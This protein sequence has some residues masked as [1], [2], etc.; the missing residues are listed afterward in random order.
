MLMAVQLFAARAGAIA[1]GMARAKVEAAAD[2]A[3][4]K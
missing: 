3:Q 4:P 2:T 1:E